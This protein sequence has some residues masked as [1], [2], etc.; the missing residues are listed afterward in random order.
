MLDFMVQL[1]QLI[2]IF[3]FKLESTLFFG[4][5]VKVRKV[6]AY[7]LLSNVPSQSKINF[8][9]GE[10]QAKVLSVGLISFKTYN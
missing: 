10:N 3:S 5:Y 9:F 7:L 8:L 2:S 6:L 1:V 4:L